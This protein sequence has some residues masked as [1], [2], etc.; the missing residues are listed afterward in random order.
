M[1]LNETQLFVKV[2]SDKEIQ[3]FILDLNRLEQLFKSGIDSEGNNLAGYSYMTEMVNRGNSF[4]YKSVSNRK[5]AGDSAFLFDSGDFYKTFEV[6]VN[7]NG[8]FIIEA[9][10]Q[11]GEDYLTD[12]YGLAILGLTDENKTELSKKMLPI[13]KEL[14]RKSFFKKVLP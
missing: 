2:V 3:E 9:D 10:D 12:R 7:K 5:L 8:S 11:K 1:Q 14:V 6:I 4:T 13:L